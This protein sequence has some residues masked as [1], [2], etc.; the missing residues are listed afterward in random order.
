MILIDL[1]A[2]DEHN[3]L[4]SRKNVYDNDQFDVFRKRTV[5]MSNIHKGKR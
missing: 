5:D 1:R 3:L 2:I 4:S